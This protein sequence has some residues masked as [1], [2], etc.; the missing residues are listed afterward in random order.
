[1]G[2]VSML[3][4]EGVATAHNYWYYYYGTC[5]N[6]SNSN[7]VW[8]KGFCKYLRRCT[9]EYKGKKMQTWHF[10][11]SGSLLTKQ[12]KN[13]R[14][15]SCVF[16]SSFF[17]IFFST[18]ESWSEKTWNGNLTQKSYKGTLNGSR[19]NPKIS[20]SFY[21][22]VMIMTMVVVVGEVLTL[23]TAKQK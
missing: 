15:S 7:E 11:P 20:F 22:P 14:S 23:F 8:N 3:T 16:F 17:Y 5:I 2:W 6:R 19:N 13:C 1:M 18:F 12:E 10:L 21:V 9:K 4:P